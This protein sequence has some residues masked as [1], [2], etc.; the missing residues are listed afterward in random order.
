MNM[1][2]GLNIELTRNREVLKCYEEIPQEVFGATMIRQAIKN[3]E[4]AILDMDT[5]AM[6]RAFQELKETK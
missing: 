2:E 1:I 5:V 6:I 4:D 3:A